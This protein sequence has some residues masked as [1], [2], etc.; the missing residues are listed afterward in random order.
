[1]PDKKT[2]E[3][4]AQDKREGKAPSIVIGNCG[5]GPNASQSMQ[6]ASQFDVS[7]EADCFRFVTAAVTV[8]RERGQYRAATA[9]S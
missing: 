6:H 4:A 8:R 2:L 7:G 1:M 5:T 3:R 9:R